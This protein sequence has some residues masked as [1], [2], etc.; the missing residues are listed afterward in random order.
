M[1]GA[2]TVD[3]QGGHGRWT[4]PTTRVRTGPTAKLDW[5]YGG[6]AQGRTGPAGRVDDRGGRDRGLQTR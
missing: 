6:L 1:T 3:G 5:A 4:G 2:D